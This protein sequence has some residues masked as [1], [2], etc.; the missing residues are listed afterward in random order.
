[1]ENKDLNKV[2]LIGTLPRDAIVKKIGANNISVANFTVTTTK[3]W[4]DPSTSTP[5]SSSQ[6]I[7][8]SA[9]RTLAETNGHLLIMGTRVRV[10]IGRAHV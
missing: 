9:W 4:M 1:M 8:V 5:K 2:E 7:V 3:K 6:Y 10:E